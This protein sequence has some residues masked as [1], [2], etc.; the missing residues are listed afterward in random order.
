[1]KQRIADALQIV[2]AVG[3][4]VATGLLFSLAVALLVGSMLAV[5]AGVVLERT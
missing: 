4:T 3:F 2:G 1:M 5:V